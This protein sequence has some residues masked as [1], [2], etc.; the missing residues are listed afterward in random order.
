MR[1]VPGSVVA[2]L[3]PCDK[4]LGCGWAA[5]RESADNKPDYSEYARS[6]YGIHE[7]L[8]R[9][10]G[11]ERLMPLKDEFAN[12]GQRIA[13]LAA[14][15]EEGARDS[16]KRGAGNGRSWLESAIWTVRDLFTRD[17]TREG[18]KDL[19]KRDPRDIFRFY[20][21]EIDFKSLQPLPWFKR[22]PIAA[23]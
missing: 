10:C 6:R 9:V 16:S 12:L 8:N 22:F 20:T 23:W 11:P 19:V 3:L 14:R 21:H 7:K 17:V 18:L 13:D 1:A 5:L 2:P 15:L 4:V